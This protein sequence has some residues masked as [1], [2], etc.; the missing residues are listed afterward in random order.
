MM[1][2]TR[3]VVTAAL[4]AVAV[5]IASPG[6][7]QAQGNSHKAAKAT[8]TSNQ[9]SRDHT[10]DQLELLR[11]ARAVRGRRVR[12][13]HDQRLLETRGIAS[14]QANYPPA[15]TGLA[16]LPTR[17]PRCSVESARTTSGPMR[18]RAATTVRTGT[19]RLACMPAR[20]TAASLPGTSA[21][22]RQLGS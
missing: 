8:T 17:I 2:M 15:S 4:L 1:S 18:S 7:A 11:L 14:R 12:D 9:A 22:F 10:T 5:A 20:T 6:D 3:S 21:F 19:R 16:K 13:S